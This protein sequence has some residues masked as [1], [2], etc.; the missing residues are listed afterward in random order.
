MIRMKICFLK[1]SLFKTL[2]KKHFLGKKI[3]LFRS[4]K[5]ANNE[6]EVNP[7]MKKAKQQLECLQPTL[8]HIFVLFETFF[9]TLKNITKIY[10]LLF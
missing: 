1:I 3:A 9:K 7:N 8:Y 6:C 2:Q 10:F 5:M 4:W